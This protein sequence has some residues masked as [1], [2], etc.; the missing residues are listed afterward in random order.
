MGSSLH[1]LRKDRK[2]KYIFIFENRGE[3]VGVT[4]PHPHGQIYAFPFIPHSLIEFNACRE[5]HEN[6]LLPHMRH[7]C[8]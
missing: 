7:G 8:R 1:Q 6:Q 2:I 3:L 4:M 5:Y